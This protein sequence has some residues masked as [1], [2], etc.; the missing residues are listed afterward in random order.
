MFDNKD[1]ILVLT[2]RP[3]H[4]DHTALVR[5]LYTDS[6]HYLLPIDNFNANATRQRQE[7]KEMKNLVSQHFQRILRGVRLQGELE[8]TVAVSEA[9]SQSSLPITMEAL[10]QHNGLPSTKEALRQHSDLPRTKEALKQQTT[11]QEQEAVQ[12]VW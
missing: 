2:G 10:E 9:G 12:T 6:G 3:P 11:S 5:V 4:D 1:G 7:Q 8:L